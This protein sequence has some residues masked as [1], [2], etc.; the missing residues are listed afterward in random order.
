MLQITLQDG[1]VFQVTNGDLHFPRTGLWMADI[2]ANGLEPPVGKI[3][4]TL[5]SVIMPA[6]VVRSE[7]VL[8]SV[9][10]RLVGGSGGLSNIATKKHF[11]RPTVRQVLAQLL[12]DAGET[13]SATSDPVT[14]NTTLEAWT[15]MADPGGAVMAALCE[16]I[17]K[18]VTWRMLFDGTVWIGPETWPACP[19]PFRSMEENGSSA[20]ELIGTDVPAVWPGTT[21]N[22][23][24]VDFVTHHLDDERTTV[25]YVT[26]P[27]AALDRTKSAFRA[28]QANDPTAAYRTLYRGKV[29]AQNGDSDQVDVR[30]DDPD[31]PD[32]AQLPLRHGIPGAR[33]SVELGSYLVVGWDNGSPDKPFAA[34]WSGDLV[35][36]KVSF[37]A[38]QVNLGSKSASHPVPQGDN[39]QTMLNALLQ[40]LT[41]FSTGLNSGTLSA[42]AVT[43]AGALP[44]IKE[45]PYL[46]PTVNVT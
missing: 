29:V 16:T 26:N 34:L 23:R 36:L 19:T 9:H 4:V 24:Q 17:G 28:L 8:G 6:A 44:V 40:A 10:V 13:L 46:S 41:T 20:T 1:S 22:G 15:T 11:R 18:G 21:L 2:S 35:P 7:L 30:P 14:L 12:G 32:M 25:M 31:L 5:A 27:G 3:T 33:V 42:Q 38:E 37:Q 43:L 39:L 45:M